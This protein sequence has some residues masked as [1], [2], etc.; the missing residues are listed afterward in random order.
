M[1]K[2]IKIFSIILVML[3]F[4]INIYKVSANDINITSNSADN[5]TIAGD[6]VSNS[7][8][9]NEDENNSGIF[10]DQLSASN[11]GAIEEEGLSLSNIISILV[12]TVGIILILLAIAILIRLK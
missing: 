5:N 3:V 11:V 2:Y 7:V 10:T 6:N 8:T 1:K 12:I 9:G 4:A